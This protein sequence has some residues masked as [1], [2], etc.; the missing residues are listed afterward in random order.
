[1]LSTLV[2]GSGGREHAIVRALSRS[3]SIKKLYAH[4]G[5]SGIFKEAESFGL[6]SDA[7]IDEIVKKVIDQ[8]LDLVVVGPE[9]PL[10]EGLSDALRI[11]GVNVVGPSA[12]GAKLEGDKIY[13]KDFM[14]EFDVPSGGYIPLKNHQDLLKALENETYKEPYVFK[15]RYLAGGKGVLVS[16]D[17]N[18]VIE[19]S[20]KYLDS[21]SIQAYLEEPL[22]GWE[23]SCICL[24]NEA[25]YKICPILQD[26]KRLKD[27]DMGPNTG[28]MG[29]AGPI[30]VD[31]KLMKQIEEDVVKPSVNGLKQRDILF[32]G[33]LYIGVM[34]TKNG[35]KVLEYNVRFG[36][37]EAQ[38]IFP[39]VESDWAQVLLGLSKGE[40]FDLKHSKKYGCS[41]VLAAEGYP[42]NPIKGAEING[43]DTI[44]PNDFYHAGTKLD[45]KV[46]KVNGGRVLNILGFGDSLE[47][48][49][50]KAYKNVESVKFSGMQSRTDIGSKIS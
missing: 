26:H 37:P 5:S 31:E 10:V 38:L 50:K 29:V 49:I 9:Q 34:V 16:K 43:L 42:E 41:V 4:P 48:A 14:K 3:E 30:K 47:E 15:Y 21:D 28:G 39:L 46:F 44:S 45:D 35:P 20:K 6:E 24:V 8:K 36:D 32:R 12:E 23:L 27:S 22:H 1:M 33:V 18:E 40:N 13:A 2:V 17:K 7:S 11:K 25:G 19:F